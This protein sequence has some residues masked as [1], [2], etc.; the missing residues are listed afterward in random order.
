MNDLINN[1]FNPSTIEIENRI[2]TIRGVQVMIDSHLAEMYDIEIRGLNQAVKRNKERFPVNYMF[3][4]TSEEWDF[5]RSQF[6]TLKNIDNKR[7][8]TEV[9]NENRGKHRKYL[10]YAFTEQGVAMLSAVLRSETAVRVS[11][12]IM[13]AFVEMRKVLT[14]NAGLFQRLEKI[15]IKQLEADR[16]FDQLFAALESKNP[17]P[18]KGIFYEGQIFDAYSFVSNKIRSAQKSIILVDNYMDDTVLTLF[19]KR[20]AGVKASF[21]TKNISKQFLLDLQKHNAQYPPIELFELKA[22]HDRFLIIDNTELYHIGASLKDLG[23]KWFAF[24]KMNTEVQ[25]MLE[26]L[27]INITE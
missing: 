9:L 15:E 16:K 17:E 22:A 7:F 25:K 13:D 6:V 5:L 26:L 4:L 3:Q 10:P 14:Q 27:N 21:Y 24:S 12:Q 23:K 18:D 1:K 8:Q 19:I 11:L 2:F 20:N